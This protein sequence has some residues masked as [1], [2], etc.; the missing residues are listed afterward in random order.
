MNN[1]P[2]FLRS[3]PINTVH[4][5]NKQILAYA[6]IDSPL[7]TIIA[8]SDD[9]K[10]YFLDFS[11]R[12]LLQKKMRKLAIAL[13]AH[14]VEDSTEPLRSIEKELK[15]YFAG[16]LEAFTTPI[17]LIGTP[18][19]ICVWQKLQTIPYGKTISYADLAT[20]IGKPTACR[21]VANANGKNML[22]III[23]CHRVINTGGGLGGYS[24]GIERKVW[25]L[26][27]EKLNQ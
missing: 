23:P 9:S 4:S 15:A 26:E 25:L 6:T 14:F 24:S 18:F 7:G 13:H 16:T 8:V 17:A 1:S 20:S 22:P 21:A 11:D 2:S 19:M 12:S 5:E 10:L 27:H 3:A